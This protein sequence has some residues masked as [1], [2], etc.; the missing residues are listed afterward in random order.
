ML[1]RQVNGGVVVYD[2]GI[3]WFSLSG[4]VVYATCHWF[5]P[6][7][8]P[9]A[10]WWFSF[11]ETTM[12]VVYALPAHGLASR[13]WWFTAGLNRRGVSVVYAAVNRRHGSV[14]YALP[15]PVI[16]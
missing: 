8:P 4:L 2:S 7:T 6:P 9:P 16:R 5:T 13:S 11:R 12:P 14:V 3:P 10:R 15:N 1:A